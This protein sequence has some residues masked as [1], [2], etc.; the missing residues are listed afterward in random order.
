MKNI[1]KKISFA[2][3][4]I[5]VLV[6]MQ[7]MACFAAEGTLQFSDPTGKVGDNITVTVKIGANGSPIGDGDATLTYDAS[8]LEF[9]S[10]TNATG[11]NGTV[12]LSASGT[13][14]E[15]ELNY[16]IVFKA[17]AEG[18]TTIEVSSSTAYLF[19]DETLN[20]QHGKSTVT[21]EAADSG[22]PSEVAVTGSSTIEIDGTTYTVYNDFSDAL[23]PDGFSRAAVSGDGYTY[24]GIRQETSGK[25]FI[26]VKKEG[27][28]DPQM[29]LCDE[30]DGFILAS[31]AMLTGEQY[32]YIL[33]EM[34]GSSLPETFGETTLDL[35]GTI[36]PVWQDSENTAFYVVNALGPSG[37]ISFYQYDTV[38]ETYQRYIVKEAAAEKEE[39]EEEEAAA[40]NELI[41]KVKAFID[42]NLIMVVAVVAAVIFILVLILIIQGVILGNKK[43][44]LEELQE[45]LQFDL[46]RSRKKKTKKQSR[47]EDEYDD[48]DDFEDDFVDFEDEDG[49]GDYEDD[50]EYDEYG[51]YDDEYDDDEYDDEYEDDEDDNYNVDFIDL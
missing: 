43:A 5:C 50:D 7:A 8:K 13:G 31:P 32:I 6:F 35:N 18:T 49:S 12:T 27:S 24:S 23:V 20:L 40:G 42:K 17:L 38:D 16:E 3:L 1:K 41:D 2:F 29:V 34:D 39:E 45:D 14:T 9:V 11:G 10:G 22:A 30:E 44:E 33:G 48:E 15:V 4:S 26:Y 21:V 36:F 51:E 25:Q 37:E 28:E 19:S 46:S 47:A